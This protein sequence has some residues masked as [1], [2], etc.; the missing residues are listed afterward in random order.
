MC[1]AGAKK[2]ADAARV[3]KRENGGAVRTM[4]G[5]RE[6]PDG[7]ARWRGDGGE[8][9]RRGAHTAAKIRTA[10]HSWAF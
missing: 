9:L 3:S 2:A 7:G 8:R 5:W 10:D 6:K 1:R 4:K